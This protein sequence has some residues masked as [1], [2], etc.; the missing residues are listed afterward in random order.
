MKRIALTLAA[1]ILSTTAAV[2][3]TDI[4][5][6]D[7]DGDGFASVAEVNAAFP[8]FSRSDFRQLD[9]NRDNRISAVELQQPDARGIV[10]RYTAGVGA[11][12]V[13]ISAIDTNGNGF[14]SFA[15]LQATYPG[16]SAVEFD[17]IDS[18]DDNRVSFDELY[19]PLA[20][21]TVS[22]HDATS[23]QVSVLSQVDTNGD[24][25]A[26]YGELLAAYP[27]LNAAD[28]RLIDA[29]NDNRISRNE[30]LRIET[31]DVLGR[32]GS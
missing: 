12:V 2:A 23:S 8:G 28:F 5:T 3:A 27:G 9:G 16:L 20:Q 32:A 25:F 13:G 11:S 21:A 24:S 22:L 7:A 26:G 29:N 31:Q 30:F 10:G 4:A 1:T 19:S 14:A 18:N 6:L 17:R 15:E